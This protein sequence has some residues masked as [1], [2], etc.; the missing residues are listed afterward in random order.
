MWL[1]IASSVSVLVAPQTTL[2]THSPRSNTKLKAPLPVPTPLL[3]GSNLTVFPSS[4]SIVWMKFP[5]T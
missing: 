4:N 3:I 5:F 1:K 2:L